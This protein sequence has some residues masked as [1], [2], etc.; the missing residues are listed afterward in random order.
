MEADIAR[1]FHD[2]YERG[3][4]EISSVLRE[5][6]ER[7]QKVLAVDYNRAIDQRLY[8]NGLLGQIFDVFDAIIT[9]GGHRR[10]PRRVGI[11]R[12]SDFLHDLDLVRCSGGDPSAPR[13]IE[14]DA[15]R[16]PV[17]WAQG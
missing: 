9:P 2:D 5:M 8:L 3:K 17:D 6:I 7:G 15:H 10:S 1:N 4:E 11:D 16:G 12:E 13:G 14:R